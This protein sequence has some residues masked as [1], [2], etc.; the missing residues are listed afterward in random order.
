VPYRG[1]RNEPAYVAQ[2]TKMLASVKEIDADK[3]ADIC[4]KNFLQLF[5]KVNANG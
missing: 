3:M 1:K 2:T 4:R 5:D